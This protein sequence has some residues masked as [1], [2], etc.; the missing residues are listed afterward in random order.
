VLFDRPKRL[1]VLSLSLPYRGLGG[2]DAGDDKP[3]A[4]PFD[5]RYDETLVRQSPDSLARPRNVLEVAH[6]RVRRKLQGH[7]VQHLGMERARRCSFQPGRRP[8]SR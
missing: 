5:M 1:R 7:P 6:L 3:A 4:V 2:G 8:G